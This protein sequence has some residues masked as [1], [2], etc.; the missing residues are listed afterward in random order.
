MIQTVVPG[1][2]RWY[3]LRVKPHHE[4][5]VARALKVNNF[6]EFLPT[7]RSRRTWSD[8]NTD[9]DLPLFAGYVF[10]RFAYEDRVPVLRTPGV[11][12]I[13]KFCS[14][15]APIADQE[16]EAIRVMLASGLRVSPWQYL[17][18]GTRVQIE[19]GPLRG[20]H[21]VLLRTKDC[22]RV[23]V[24]VA[25]LQRS[26]AIEIDRELISAVSEWRAAA[27]MAS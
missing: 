11:V 7:Y 26:V 2:S 10:C 3:A 9:L 24:S 21:G 1:K 6:E 14:I 20:L 16:I 22:W 19:H 18:E 23:V 8:R 15:P 5:A 25:M 4:K 17:R 27:Q 13:I 12:S